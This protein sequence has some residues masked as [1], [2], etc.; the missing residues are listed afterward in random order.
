MFDLSGI[1]PFGLLVLFTIWVIKDY[2]RA[3][4]NKSVNIPTQLLL[5]L[6]LSL[7]FVQMLLEP[8]M[9]SVPVFMWCLL[10]ICGMQSKVSHFKD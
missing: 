4:V 3:A 5:L 6:V 9:E 2:K 7:S 8:T 1:V 10:L